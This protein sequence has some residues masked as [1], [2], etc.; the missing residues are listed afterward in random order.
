M[1]E[2]TDLGGLLLLGR[3]IGSDGGP[4][5]FGAQPVHP[6]M[7]HLEVRVAGVLVATGQPPDTWS[8]NE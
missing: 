7:A 6:Q 1:R 3:T 4:S 5:T 2:G 8:S